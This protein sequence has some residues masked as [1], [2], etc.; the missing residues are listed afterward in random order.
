MIFSLKD[1]FALMPE[2]II[3]GAACVLLGFDPLLKKCKD[4]TGI[5]SI[6]TIVIAAIATCCLLS[7][8]LSG[9][10]FFAGM[11]KLDLFSSYF[12][13]LFYGVGF[14]VM[15]MSFKYVKHEGI[16]MGEY[17]IMMLFSIVGMMILVSA[18]DLLSIYV[19]LELMS[20][21]L[22][23]L[24]G[25]RQ[26]S[27]QSNEGSMKYVIMGAFSSAILLYGISF[28]YGLT[29]T[30][31]LAG[32]ALALGDPATAVPA[33]SIAIVMLVAGFG[34]KI[35]GVP[36]HMWA[37]DVYQGAPTPVTSFMSTAPK[38]AAFAVILRVFLVA[39]APAYDQWVVVVIVIAVLSMAYGNYVALSQ[40]S[41]K[42]MLAYSSI[43]HAGY[44][45]LGLVAG[46]H[47]GVASVLFYMAVYAFMN[48]GVFAVIVLVTINGRGE[49]IEDY[50]GLGKT[51]K[52]VAVLMMIF[53]FSLAGIPP[54]A[55]FMGKLYIF[56]ALLDNGMVALAIFAVLMSA[57]AAYMYL[58]V[59]MVMYMKEPEG[60]FEMYRPICLCFVILIAAVATVWYGVFPR[61]LVELAQLASHIM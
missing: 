2:L 25:F 47:D 44:A 49:L 56:M 3:V 13:M 53:L 26:S 45:L 58:R 57:V 28:I 27:R 32:I 14:L 19:G 60:E 51:N 52:L 22:Y 33:L 15:L 6:I 50:R 23:V 41:I 35:A 1:V 39:L 8:D 5:L 59:I 10:T 7:G 9:G 37:P 36:F 30:T 24:A 11:Y 12:K 18:V 16:N 61:V 4:L 21:P 55:G 31:D 43:G 54:M 46:T 34:F 42:R 17:Y 38:A 48:I 29:G 20:V 40:K